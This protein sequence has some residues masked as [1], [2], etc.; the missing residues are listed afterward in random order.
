MFFN[1]PEEVPVQVLEILCAHRMK[2]MCKQETALTF[3]KT[4]VPHGFD[5][6]PF[7]ANT[8]GSYLDTLRSIAATLFYRASVEEW[9]EKGI[10]FSTYVYIPEV[11]PTTN[12]VHHDRAD[13]GHL[14]KRIACKFQEKS[15]MICMCVTVDYFS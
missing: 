6:Y 13:H 9:K 11:D 15:R 3:R 1:Q 4:L 14:L 10:D 5:F 7:R 2:G 8:P 12:T